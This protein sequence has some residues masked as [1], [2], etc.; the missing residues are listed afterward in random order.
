[1][2]CLLTRC[3]LG[4]LCD[5]CREDIVTMISSLTPTD[6]GATVENLG[7]PEVKLI[8]MGGWMISFSFSVA[9]PFLSSFNASTAPDAAVILL[10]QG[11]SRAGVRITLF[12]PTSK[13]LPLSEEG[14]AR[15]ALRYASPE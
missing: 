4:V 12:V 15:E 2:H 3:V 10:G 5:G 13:C 7:D 9:S 11:G 6:E 1:M 14:T 8:G